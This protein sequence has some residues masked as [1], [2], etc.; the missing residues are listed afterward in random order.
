MQIN[1][2]K[3]LIKLYLLIQSKH[4]NNLKKFKIKKKIK[5]NKK[6][7]KIQIKMKVTMNNQ[8]KIKIK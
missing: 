1:N 6:Q 2:K 5:I 3:T 4:K 7:M 8:M